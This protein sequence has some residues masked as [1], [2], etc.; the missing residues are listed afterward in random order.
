[1]PNLNPSNGYTGAGKLGRS[2]LGLGKVGLGKFGSG[3]VGR[4]YRAEAVNSVEIS[5]DPTT[6][7]VYIYAYGLGLTVIKL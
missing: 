1:M 5:R 6:F 7:V 3:N 2:K 4:R